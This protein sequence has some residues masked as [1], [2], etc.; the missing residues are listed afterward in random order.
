M[1]RQVQNRVRCLAHDERLA[2]HHRE[3]YGPWYVHQWGYGEVSRYH[4]L[5]W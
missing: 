1:M 2:I 4:G 3:I 5:A